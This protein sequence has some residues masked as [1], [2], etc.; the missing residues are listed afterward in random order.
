[1]TRLGEFCEQLRNFC[2]LKLQRAAAERPVRE[3]RELR[4]RLS[5]KSPGTIAPPHRSLRAPLLPQLHRPRD[6]SG[7]K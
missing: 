4:R 1:M 3:A 2:W 7:D 5:E 6:E